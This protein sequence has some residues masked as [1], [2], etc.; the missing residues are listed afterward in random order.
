MQW[1]VFA[2]DEFL[3]NHF[4][5]CISYFF[6]NNQDNYKEVKKIIIEWIENNYEKFIDFFG[7]DDIS[8]IK[9]EEIALN[10]FEY[11]K[12]KDSWGSDYTISIACLLFIIDIAVYTFNGLNEYK[13]YNLFTVENDKSKELLILS[14]HENNHFDII[15]SIKEHLENNFLYND[16][17]EINIK[18][19]LKK[20]ILN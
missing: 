5:R 15:Y 19:K 7:D 18:K 6:T 4:Y 20:K 17:N 1:R 2:T 3:Q 16:I 9:K 13:S 11:I 8:G 10:E 12:S 14:Y